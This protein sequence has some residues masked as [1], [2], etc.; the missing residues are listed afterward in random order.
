MFAFEQT[1]PDVLPYNI[2]IQA[3]GY[4]RS[5]SVSEMITT[6]ILTF[7]ELNSINCF[8]NDHDYKTFLDSFIHG[9]LHRI[10]LQMPH[11]H[12]GLSFPLLSFSGC[13]VEPVQSLRSPWSPST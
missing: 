7:L 1:I 10:G 3:V 4:C 12:V 9:C 8:G 6:A 13:I 2:D 5:S 11:V